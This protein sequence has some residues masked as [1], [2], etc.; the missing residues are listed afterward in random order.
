M[1]LSSTSH[2]NFLPEVSIWINISFNFDYLN[3]S[4]NLHIGLFRYRVHFPCFFLFG[5]VLWQERVGAC[6]LRLLFILLF[7]VLLPHPWCAIFACKTLS[8]TV[9]EQWLAIMLI[10]HGY[11]QMHNIRG[12]VM[13][14]QENMAWM[15]A[16]VKMPWKY[17][18]LPM[19]ISEMVLILNGIKR[20]N[21]MNIS[22]RS[23][24]MW[25]RQRVRVIVWC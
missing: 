18:E 10:S 12:V 22:H 3:G 15:C 6:F 17:C 16:C 21:S 1:T 19:Q 20:Y 24:I 23:Q 7:L 2:N 5:C 9:K 4:S 13:V 11:N 14:E 8:V 25:A